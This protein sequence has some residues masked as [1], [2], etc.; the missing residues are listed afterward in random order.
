MP[1]LT[2]TPA[3][4]KT[5]ILFALDK[6]RATSSKVSSSVRALLAPE[7]IV[8]SLRFPKYA[9]GPPLEMDVSIPHGKEQRT[10]TSTKPFKQ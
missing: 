1:E 7:P 10:K 5:V 6:V 9:H 2:L 8:Y 3:P 4:E